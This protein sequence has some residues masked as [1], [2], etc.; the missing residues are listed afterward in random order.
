MIVRIATFNAQNLFRRPKAFNLAD[1]TQ[2]NEVLA[3]FSTLVSLLNLTTYDAQ[4]KAR[5][6][7][8]VKKHRAN[9]WNP[10][11]PPPIYINETRPGKKSSLFKEPGSTEIKATGRGTWAGWAE[12]VREELDTEAVRNTGR[13]VDAVDADIL[14]VV[15]VEDRLTLDRFN[16]QILAGVLGKRPYPFN[17]LIDGNDSRGIDI[18]IL[19]RH[20]ITSVRSHLFD[21]DPDRPGEPLFSR[22]CP[23]FEIELNGAPLI[24]LGNHLKSKF[25]DDPAL[26][27]A[28]AK[29]VAEIYE[30]ARERTPH[31]VVAGDLNDDLK[32]E[33]LEVLLDTGLQDVMTH[34]SYRGGPG[35]HGQCDEPSDKLDYLLLPPPLR[36]RV[37]HVALEKRGIY[38]EPPLPDTKRFEEVTSKINAAS[39]HAALYVDLDF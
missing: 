36:H 11:D 7:A 22:D 16:Q 8:L 34:S 19:S 37:Q 32:S 26:R 27:L 14:V 3:D 21:P 5:I 30:A 12:L 23:E 15:E 9:A 28:Q 17:M 2:R 38:W 29:R 31:V 39:D 6:S 18:G 25:M 24:V 20:P 13:V 1:A 4:D 10:E 35:T 33:P